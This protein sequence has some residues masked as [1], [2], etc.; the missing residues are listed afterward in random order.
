MKKNADLGSTKGTRRDNNVFPGFNDAFK[1]LASM[2]SVVT[3]NV[4]NPDSLGALED[5][6]VDSRIGPEMKIRLDI[7]NTVDIG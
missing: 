7:H 5:D 4:A 6:S 3:W 1:E 2:R